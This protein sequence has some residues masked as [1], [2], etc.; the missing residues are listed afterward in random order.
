[1]VLQNGD[2]VKIDFTG[3][4]KETGKVFDTTIEKVAKENDIYDEN[5]KFKAAPIVVGANHVLKGLDEALVG[6][7]VGEKKHAEVLP[8]GTAVAA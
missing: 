1:M 7:E 8:L 4:V 2:F 6:A 3:K 5:V